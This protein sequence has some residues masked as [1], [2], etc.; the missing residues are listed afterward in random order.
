[1]PFAPNTHN[2]SAELGQIFLVGDLAARYADALGVRLRYTYGVSDIFA[3]DA[4]FGYSNHSD[5]KFT[6][7]NGL[8]GVRLN[9]SWFDRIVPHGVFGLG[10]YRPSMDFD[11]PEPGLATNTSAF[12]FGI[13]AGVGIDLQVSKWIFFGTDVMFHTMFAPKQTIPNAPGLNGVFASF[14]VH[15]GVSF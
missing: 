2:I 7:F 6:M 11:Q 10:F 12:L 15:A 14:M 4:S 5:G 9:I 3:F 1:M 8:A 13:H